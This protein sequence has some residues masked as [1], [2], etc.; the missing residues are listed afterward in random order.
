MH[1]RFGQILC[2]V[3]TAVC[4]LAS[5]AH[6]EEERWALLVGIDDYPDELGISDLSGSVNDIRQ[7]ERAL[8]DAAGFP[9]HQ[10]FTLTS[11]D[12]GNLPTLS[13]IKEHL[14]HIKKNTDGDDFVYLHFSMHGIMDDRGEA[15]LLPLYAQLGESGTFLSVAQLESDVRQMGAKQL[16]V[17]DACRNDPQPARGEADNLMDDGFADQFAR[18]VRIVPVAKAPMKRFTQFVFACQPGQRAFEWPGEERGVFSAALEKGLRGEGKDPGDDVTLGELLE[19][20]EREVP[21]LAQLHLAGAE[22][23]PDLR[24]LRPAVASFRVSRAMPRKARPPR[25]KGNA[26]EPVAA[27]PAPVIPWV[28]FVRHPAEVVDRKSRE[29]LRFEIDTNVPKDV[30]MFTYRLD[31]QQPR[32]QS[33]T[34]LSLDPKREP[35]LRQSGTH[36]LQLTVT[37]AEGVRSEPAVF[38]FRVPENR[39]PVIAFD[40]P[41]QGGVVLPGELTI[42]LKGHDA[43]GELTDY[44]LGVNSPDV[45]TTYPT[46]TIPLKLDSGEY[47]LFARVTDDE[48]E[49]SSWKEID[50]TVQAAALEESGTEAARTLADARTKL[51]AGRIDD[52][53]ALFQ[54]LKKVGKDDP[55][56]RDLAK[57][58]LADCEYERYVAKAKR[59]GGGK[60]A[61][62][63]LGNAIRAYEGL[64]K[65]APCRDAGVLATAFARFRLASLEHDLYEYWRKMGDQRKMRRH[66]IKRDDHR[67][68]L[69]LDHPEERDWNGKLLLDRL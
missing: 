31:D 34:S 50:I 44:H 66:Q 20:V 1:C 54:Q 11:D 16:V 62:G 24:P 57:F 61:L 12:R 15:Y 25:S 3:V 48:G 64:L 69:R 36:M 30:R 21:V 26:L 68:R 7:I 46:G 63:E 6:G 45:F 60:R 51:S 14:K 41:K 28:E 52:A 33:S 19:Y 13:K 53:E 22:Q 42:L 55:C 32:E 65:V 2:G 67:S 49:S 40:H 59:G 37:D 8:I 17:V 47:T 29:A 4:C 58:G 56:A 39:R 43:D 18:G 35:A 10:V 9:A 5:G 23:N 38:E 27:E